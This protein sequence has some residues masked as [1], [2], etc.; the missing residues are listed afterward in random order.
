MKDEETKSNREFLSWLAFWLQLVVLAFLA[1]V[2]F[3]FASLARGRGDYAIGFGLGICAIAL[4]FLRLKLSFDGE[5]GGWDD[6]L[7][8]D[9]MAQLAIAI[10]VLAVLG[11]AGL[12]LA[13]AAGSGGLY[14]A[15][16]GLFVASA[17]S[18]FLNV[19]RVYDRIDRRRH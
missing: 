16:L 14:A 18:I 11:L 15:G 13:H 12:F 2:G 4:A 10:P 5:G 19:K 6:I 3:V 17:V 9:T 8:V 7:F 1:V